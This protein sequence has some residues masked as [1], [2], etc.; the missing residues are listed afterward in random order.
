MMNMT[1]AD[2]MEFAENKL[3]FEKFY[4]LEDQIRLR[5]LWLGA[6]AVDSLERIAH[7]LEHGQLSI[8]EGENIVSKL[9]IIGDRI[10]D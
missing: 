1:V 5:K 4:S 10:P 3:Q 2:I 9:S 6:C 7:H 8:L